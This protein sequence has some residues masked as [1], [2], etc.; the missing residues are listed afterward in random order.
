MPY[1]IQVVLSPFQ[2]LENRDD[3]GPS[4]LAWCRGRFVLD[5]VDDQTW[6]LEVKMALA[7]YDLRWCQCFV[8]N[9]KDLLVS[10]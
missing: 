7:R 6:L 1:G 8:Q 2:A 10:G 4:I 3:A 9:L 5:Q